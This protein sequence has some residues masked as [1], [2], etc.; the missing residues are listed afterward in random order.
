MRPAY[1]YGSAYP[2]SYGYG[3]GYGGAFSSAGYGGLGGLG[4][5]SAGFGSTADGPIENR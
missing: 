4:G 5:Y 3:Q 1:G 2:S